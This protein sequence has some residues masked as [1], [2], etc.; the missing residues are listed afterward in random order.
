MLGYNTKSLYAY[1]NSGKTWIT[2]LLSAACSLNVFAASDSTEKKILFASTQN[3]IE[4]F[5]IV[6]RD[7]DLNNETE[8]GYSISSEEYNHLLL[9]WRWMSP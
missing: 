9:M 8:D 5:H 7:F 6:L 3:A 2:V 4:S 1:R